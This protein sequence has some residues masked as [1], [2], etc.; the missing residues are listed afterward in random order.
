MKLV[1]SYER[2]FRS[3]C[4]NL[5]LTHVCSPVQCA[6]GGRARVPG[7]AGVGSVMS[8]MRRAVVWEGFANIPLL[9]TREQNQ[10]GIAAAS[11]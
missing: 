11:D 2:G 4:N 6:R 9:L 7:N 8:I 1:E 5:N 3:N 10:L